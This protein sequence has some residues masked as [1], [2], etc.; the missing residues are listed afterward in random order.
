M[1]WFKETPLPLQCKSKCNVNVNCHI[2][3]YLSFSFHCCWIET[4]YRETRFTARCE[5]ELNKRGTEICI[6]IQLFL[7]FQNHALYLTPGYVFNITNL[8]KYT[9]AEMHHEHCHHNEGQNDQFLNVIIF[10]FLWNM[11]KCLSFTWTFHWLLL[12]LYRVN[13]IFFP[14]HFNLAPTQDVKCVN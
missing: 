14:L 7:L 13:D 3:G 11:N 10:N 12:V 5:R 9:F 4:T 2:P 8:C 1:K 6:F